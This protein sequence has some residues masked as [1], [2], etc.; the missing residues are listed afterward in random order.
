MKLWA[1]IL[2]VLLLLGLSAGGYVGYNLV[3]ISVEDVKISSLESVSVGTFTISGA[4][5]L[6][7]PSLV[8]VPLKSGQYT[9]TLEDGNTELGHGTIDSTTISAN[10][11]SNLPFKQTINWMPASEAL[12]RLALKEHV[13]GWVKGTLVI[14]IFGVQQLSLPFEQR[15]DL[16]GYIKSLKRGIV[17]DLVKSVMQ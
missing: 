12:L 16:S 6:K 13:Y 5:Q 3:K 2:C 10:S 14:D 4:I 7:N 1:F 11:V 8:S 9:I 17:Q 15:I